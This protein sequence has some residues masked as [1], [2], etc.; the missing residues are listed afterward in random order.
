MKK[1]G[2]QVIFHSVEP[3][4]RE[5]FRVSNLATLFQFAENEAAAV[6][7]AEGLLGGGGAKGPVKEATQATE[8]TDPASSKALPTAPPP[9]RRSRPGREG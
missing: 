1:Q 5:V 8:G 7:M 3:T 9:L 6:E 4:V 2:A